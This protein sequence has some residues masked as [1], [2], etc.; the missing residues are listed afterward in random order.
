MSAGRRKVADAGVLYGF[1]HVFYWELK[2]LAEGAFR[3]YVDKPK[4]ERLKRE[5]DAT[6][7]TDD[8]LALLKQQVLYELETGSIP[9][10]FKA[11][12]LAE[13]VDRALFDIKFAKHNA[14]VDFSR[15]TKRVPGEPDIIAQLLG[16]TRPE[17]IVELCK[18]AFATWPVEIEPGVITEVRK[19][20]WP[21]P[22]G[23]TLPMYLSQHAAAFIEAKNDPRFPKSSRPSSQLKQ[24]WFVARAL[25]G[26]IFGVSTRTAINLV[27]SLRPDEMF[28]ES[29][30][31]KLARKPRKAKQVAKR[32]H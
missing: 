31:G 14:A 7:L 1:A 29:R 20:N 12:R 27:G 10:H 17:Q 26:A 21:I 6:Q 8:Q 9:E 11:Q 23:S 22:G 28:H 25:A 32:K 16:A 2:T 15:Q 5:A 13:L 30:E 4:L 19:P 18:D 24:F 3:V